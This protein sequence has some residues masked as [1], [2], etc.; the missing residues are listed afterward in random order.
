MDLGPV[1]SGH[2]PT[3]LLSPCPAQTSNLERGISQLIEHAPSPPSPR[4]P[5]SREE[6]DPDQRWADL[7]GLLASEINTRTGRGRPPAQPRQPEAR[8]PG[9]VRVCTGPVPLGLQPGRL[10]PC[11]KHESPPRARWILLEVVAPVYAPEGLSASTSDA[12][13][14]GDRGCVGGRSFQPSPACCHLGAPSRDPTRLQPGGG[15]RGAG[16]QR[17]A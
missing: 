4:P 14:C 12:E 11:P 7:E 6:L 17:V 9:S 5:G 10:V 8:L 3:R 15:G 13:V 2:P 16:S 1:S